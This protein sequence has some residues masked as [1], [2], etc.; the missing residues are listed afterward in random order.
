[1]H[2]ESGRLQ[3]GP[4]RGNS[5]LFFVLLPAHPLIKT[6]LH[7]FKEDRFITLIHPFSRLEWISL[8]VCELAGL[9]GGSTSRGQQ[10]GECR[11]QYHMEKPQPV[12]ISRESPREPYI[13]T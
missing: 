8:K 13:K 6:P 5:T 1:M 11:K 4:R 10:D 9:K 7:F 12:L 2:C 3:A